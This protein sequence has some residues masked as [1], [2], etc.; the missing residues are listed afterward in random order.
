MGLAQTAGMVITGFAMFGG[1]KY[2]EMVARREERKQNGSRENEI[3]ER[4]RS[5]VGRPEEVLKEVYLGKG[6]HIE[7]MLVTGRI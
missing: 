7:K 4:A 1:A 5:N 3:M 2:D 6:F